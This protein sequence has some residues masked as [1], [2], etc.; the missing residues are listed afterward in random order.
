LEIGLKR[1]RPAAYGLEEY[2]SRQIIEKFRNASLYRTPG[3]SC[4]SSN[5][6]FPRIIAHRGLSG[7]CPENT[8]PSFG[9]AVAAGAHEI[10]F[11][12][13][14]SKDSKLVICHD[15]S[16]DR[17]SNGKGD[18]CNLEWSNYTC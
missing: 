2:G 6:P 14:G 13:W 10:E 7:L 18:I 1:K 17:T 15:K 8:L 9:S 5:L 3:P 11:D 4:R 12:I 16:I